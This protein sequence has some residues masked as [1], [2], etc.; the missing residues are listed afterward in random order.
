MVNETGKAAAA[1]AAGDGSSAD[2]TPTEIA[3]KPVQASVVTKQRIMELTMRIP[4]A[5][6]AVTFVL[7][8]IVLLVLP[9]TAV[10]IFAL[11]GTAFAAL[12]FIVRAVLDRV[13]TTKT[14]ERA[15]HV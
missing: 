2:A 8:F 11:V 7:M 6:F 1:A 3:K 5:A 9:R 14:G 15:L 10:D 4:S 12:V 13:R